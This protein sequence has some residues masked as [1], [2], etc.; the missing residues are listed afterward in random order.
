MRTPDDE[1]GSPPVRPPARVQPPRVRAWGERA[2]WVR[3]VGEPTVPIG[4]PGGD[5]VTQRHARSVIDLALRVGEAMLATGASAADV[6]ATVLRLTAAYG[7]HSAH[8]DVTFT[9]V[10]VSIHRGLDEDPLSVLRVV[11]VRS[12]D[13]TRLENVQ[14]LVDDVVAAHR[15]G[16]ALDVEADRRRLARI[17]TRPHPYRRWVVT[18]GSALV[19]AG[20]VALFSTNPLMWLLAAAS[21]AAVDQL[22]RVLGS[23][24]LSAF[25]SQAVSAAVPTTLAVLIYWLRSQG[26][27]LPYLGSP[28]LLVIS[29]IIVLLAGLTVM[30]AAQ[31]ALDGYYVTAGA[32][33]LEVLVLTLGIAVGIALVLGV[34]VRLGVPLQVSPHLATAGTPVANT[35]AAMVIGAG[36]GLST[37]SRG[38]ATLAASVVAGLGWV[39]YEL[40][41]LLALDVAV[42]VALAAMV[43]GALA[44]AGHRWLRVPEVAL[45][46][47]GIVTMLP[48][49]AVYRALFQFVENPGVLAPA[50]LAQAATAGSIGLGLAAGLSIGGYLA[51]RRFGLDRAAQ[52]A[53]RRAR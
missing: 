18:A 33:A 39:S 15:R 40:A 48:G 32:R 47:A 45:G 16:E 2:S 38:R 20:V 3:G 10:T 24:G 23:I 25:F 5:A 14:R 49:L 22:Q 27:D 51:R 50:A 21:A 41:R 52:R 43:V 53:L 36:F 37:Y 34:A 26:V 31:D 8:V 46:T 6:V 30:G 29:G 42:T 35:V 7:I 19:A 13:F 1:R 11:R 44:H 12:R 4:V 9:S 28:S 17:L